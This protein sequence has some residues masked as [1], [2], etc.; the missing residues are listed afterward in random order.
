MKDQQGMEEGGRE[1]GVCEG[2]ARNGGGRGGREGFVKD[3]QG[4][5]R[6]GGGRELRSS[7]NEG[8]MRTCMLVGGYL[9]RETRSISRR[10]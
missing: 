3:Q 7:A 4:M 2:S 10:M 6:N 5:G 1:R 9:A 8:L